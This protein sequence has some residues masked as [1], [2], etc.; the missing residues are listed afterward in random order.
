MRNRRRGLEAGE[1]PVVRARGRG[2]VKRF[3]CEADG[4]G[5]WSTGLGRTSVCRSEVWCSRKAEIVVAAHVVGV[6]VTIIASG[7]G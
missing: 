1:R 2:D 7:A 3:T 6:E 5:L 4:S